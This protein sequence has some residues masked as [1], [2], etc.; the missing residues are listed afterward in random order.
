CPG[1]Q[2]DHRQGL[3]QPGEDEGIRRGKSPFFI[4]AELRPDK[5]DGVGDA[6]LGGQVPQV[7]FMT[8]LIPA[9]DHQAPGAAGRFAGLPC[10]GPGLKKRRKTLL[11]VKTTEI[12]QD[13]AGRPERLAPGWETGPL[14]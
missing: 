11:W 14:R 1:F 7:L 5:L 6:K 12:E 3:A 9:A 2:H 4:L 8:V 13:I 10:R